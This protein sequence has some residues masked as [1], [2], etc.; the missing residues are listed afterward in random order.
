MEND[1]VA[2]SEETDP[3]AGKVL[4][5]PDPD[6][7]RVDGPEVVDPERRARHRR[8]VPDRPERWIP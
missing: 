1:R 5:V 3:E 4:D 2:D 6:T 7:G 8:W